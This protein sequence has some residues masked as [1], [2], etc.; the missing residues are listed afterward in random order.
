MFQD[1]DKLARLYSSLVHHAISS[2]SC[3][4]VMR[5]FGTLRAH[6]HRPGLQSS[7]KAKSSA[8]P[9]G[10]WRASESKHSLNGNSIKFYDK[11]G[12]VLRVETTVVRPE[13]FK[14]Y[15]RPE[16]RAQKRPSAG[17]RCGEG[18]RTWSAELEICHRANERYFLQAL[19]SASGTVPLFQRVENIAVSLSRV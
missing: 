9:S 14:T 3:A 6:Q 2:F 1:P 19:G 12:W 17:C 10:G 11:Q 13:E 16:G 5:F 15:R 4:D 18:W 8:T 7:S